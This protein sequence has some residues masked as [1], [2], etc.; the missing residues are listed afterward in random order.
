MTDLPDTTTELLALWN[1]WS[2]LDTCLTAAQKLTATGNTTGAQTLTA[3]AEKMRQVDPLR[4]LAANHRLARLLTGWQWHAVLAAR[5]AG[6]SWEQIADATDTTPY[7]A[8]CDFLLRIGHAEAY[9]PEFTDLP[10]YRAALADR[11]G[12]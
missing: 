3:A 12:E 10:R 2:E 11:D 5:E 1:D 8:R 9:A 7:A 4:A 6:A